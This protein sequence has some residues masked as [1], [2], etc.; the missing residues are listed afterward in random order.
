MRVLVGHSLGGL[1]AVYAL[2]RRPDLFTGYVVMEPSLWWND[3][4]HV[5][6]IR[7]VL[8]APEARRARLMMVNAQELGVDTTAWGGGAPMVRHLAIAGET[9]SSMALSGMMQAF[10][11]MFADFRPTEWRPGTRPI[12]MLERHDSL[13][14]RVGYEVPINPQAFA[15][16][17]RMSLDSRHFADAEAVLDRMERS[18]G[19]SDQSRRLRER[20]QRERAGPPPP[21]FLPLEFPARRPS[22]RDA[23]RFL[24]RWILDQSDPSHEVVIRASGDTIIVRDRIRFP[25]GTWNE[26]DHPVIQVTPDGTLEWGLP[27]FRGI[28]ALLVLQGRMLEDGSMRVTR[29]VRGWVPRGPGPELSRVDWFRRVVP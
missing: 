14:A 8:R 19:P 5:D 22:P 18:L 2:I 12:A 10:K 16:V 11:T 29:Q 17:A 23:A 20:L 26:G 13:S 25:D 6:E 27:W 28:A 1:F 3:Q 7:A 24:G 21:G 4:R 9:H 15:L